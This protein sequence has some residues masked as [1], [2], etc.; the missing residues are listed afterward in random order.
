MKIPLKWLLELCPVDD[1]AE[2]IARLLTLSGTEVEDI[3]DFSGSFSGI[4]VGEVIEVRPDDPTPGMSRCT[5]DFGGGETAQVLSRAPNIK[6]GSLYPFAPAGARLF[7]GKEIRIVEFEGVKSE[8]MLCSG[9]EIGLGEPKDRL[10]EIPAGTKVGADVLKLLRWDDVVFEMEVTPNRPDCYGVLGLAREL[11]ALTQVPITDE[12]HIPVETGAQAAEFISIELKDTVGCPRY[13]ARIIENIEVGHSPLRIIGRLAASGIRPI[14]NVVD[15]TNYVLLLLSHPLHAFDYDKLKSKKIVVRSAKKGEK[16]VTLDNEERTL[17]EGHLLIAT[18]D[19]AVAIAGVMGGL[20]SEVDE[21][22]TRILLE[23]AYFDPRRIRRTSRHL[24]LVSESS[25]RF[26]RGVDPNGAARASDEC[27]SL[28]AFTAGGEVRKGMVDAYPKPIEPLTVELSEK[29]VEATI[30][31]KIPE[32]TYSKYLEALGI[33]KL[34]KGRWQVPTYRPDITREIDLVEEVGRLDCYDRLKPVLRGGGPIPARLPD[35]V[36]LER[37]LARILPG[38]GFT[39]VMCDSLGKKRDFEPFIEKGISEIANPISDDYRYLRP[40]I[41]PGLLKVASYNLNR[42][43]ESVRIYEYDKVHW[44]E[45]GEQSE[46]YSLGVLMAGLKEPVGWDKGEIRVDI[47]DFRGV[48]EAVLD[49]LGVEYLIEPDTG[50]LFADNV[51][52]AI[53]SPNGKVLGRFGQIELRIAEIFDIEISVFGLEMPAESLLKAV[54]RIPQ[55]GGIPKFPSTRRDVALIV[56]SEIPAGEILKIARAHC[57]D[58]LEKVF[59]FDIYEG[60]PIPE[61]KKSVGLAS[62]FRDPEKTI[63]DEE[64]SELHEKMVEALAKKFKAEIRE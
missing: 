45:K 31:I 1:D 58:K 21:N 13:T 50:K 25:I 60:A 54:K 46:R 28:I 39:E 3:I 10:L 57:S 42:G 15:A 29:K 40:S 63:T 23:S 5:V 33:K 36:K 27:A 17:D 9:V 38:L 51:S 47:F 43:A 59:I 24:G 20:D 52:L 32:K 62:I 30:G 22:T 16:F 48:V 12:H 37:K 56:E 49:S 64:A 44:P 35:E 7:G 53:K 11:S 4:V 18:P 14:N 41:L 2:K 55:F 8:G 6:T 19:R 61:G 34:Q 26:E